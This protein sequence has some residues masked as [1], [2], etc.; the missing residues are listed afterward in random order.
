M[1]VADMRAWTRSFHSFALLHYSKLSVASHHVT[2]DWIQDRD[3]N[4]NNDN[5]NAIEE[6]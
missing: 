4:D 2:K 1:V 3:N 5:T 6:Q